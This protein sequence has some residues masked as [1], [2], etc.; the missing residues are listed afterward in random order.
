MGGEERL[1]PQPSFARRGV[2]LPE[3]GSL[4]GLH[5]E[6][7]RGEGALREDRLQLAVDPLDPD[8]QPRRDDAHRLREADVAGD[9][10]APAALV[11]R[12]RRVADPDPAQHRRTEA[13]DV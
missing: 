10:S 11:E 6:R 9:S 13:G 4:A 2:A 8:A 5:D 1:E 3:A 12:L 7:A